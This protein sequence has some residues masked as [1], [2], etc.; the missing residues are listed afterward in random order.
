MLK[1]TNF[2]YDKVQ[3]AKSLPKI[4]HIPS[5]VSISIQVLQTHLRDTSMGSK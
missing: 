2:M 5:H 1:V 3:E 4:H